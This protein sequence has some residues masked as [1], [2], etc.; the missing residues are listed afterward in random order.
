MCSFS[1]LFF[2]CCWGLL[3]FGMVRLDLE[4]ASWASDAIFIVLLNRVCYVSFG[5]KRKYC[6]VSPVEN[7]GLCSN[8][9]GRGGGCYFSLMPSWVAMMPPETFLY[10]SLCTSALSAAL[11]L[12][13]PCWGGLPP[14]FFEARRPSENFVPPALRPLS[15]LAGDAISVSGFVALVVVLGWLDFFGGSGEACWSRRTG[16]TILKGLFLPSL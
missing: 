15:L 16:R 5:Y 1:S 13:L 7:R 10:G 14:F 12:F 9:F 11:L 6:D 4:F 3:L 8:V 2:S